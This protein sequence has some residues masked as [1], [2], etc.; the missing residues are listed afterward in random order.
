MRF[1]LMFVATLFPIPLFQKINH[2]P[3]TATKIYCSKHSKHGKSFLV[4]GGN[5]EKELEENVWACRLLLI[6]I[7]YLLKP[8][9]KE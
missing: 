4:L 8:M 2:I 6:H 1:L 7:F 3:M 5:V 9:T